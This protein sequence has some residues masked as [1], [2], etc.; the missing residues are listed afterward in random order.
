M[1]AVHWTSRYLA[2]N[3][4]IAHCIKTYVAESDSGLVYRSSSG[5]AAVAA[6][7]FRFSPFLSLLHKQQ[8]TAIFENYYQPFFQDIR[9]FAAHMLPGT[10]AL[11]LFL[12]PSDNVQHDY[13]NTCHVTPY[14]V[15]L[16]NKMVPRVMVV[17]IIKYFCWCVVVLSARDFFSIL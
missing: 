7:S 13:C 17:L 11:L 1:F 8:Y 16:N 9:T 6:A 3:W 14:Y 12:L 5:S 4:R 10:H 2:Q 15:K